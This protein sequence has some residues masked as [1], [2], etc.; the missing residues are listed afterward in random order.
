MKNVDLVLLWAGGNQEKQIKDVEDLI[1]R[2]VDG[3]LIG[4]VQQAGSMVAVDAAAE[5]K[6]PVVT[7]GRRSNSTKSNAETFFD[8]AKFGVTQIQQVAKDFPNGANLVYLFGPVGAG[9]A[10]QQYE[11]GVLPELK[12]YP[13]LK[14]LDT[15]KHENDT[16]ALG[17]KSAEDALVRFPNIDAFVA[18]NDDM[19]FGAARAAEAAGKLGKIKCYG[20]TAVPIGLQAIYDG[21]MV[22]TNLKS[23][24]KLASQTMD[25]LLKIMNGEKVNRVNMTDPVSITRENLL[26]LRDPGFS[27]TMDN[28]G[29]W[30][31]KK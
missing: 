27:G 29:T 3:I 11:E 14:L 22:F 4:P 13:K 9:Y 1:A 20:N 8:E 26:T 16:T 31:P 2:K 24:A 19:A 5:A 30:T 10:V 12:K 17:M 23:Q 25:L 15:Y 7:F 6:I 18:N 21:K 28:P